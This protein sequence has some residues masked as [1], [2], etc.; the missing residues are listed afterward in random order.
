MLVNL[1]G[2]IFCFL[3][4]SAPVLDRRPSNAGPGDEGWSHDPSWLADEQQLAM[5]DCCWMLF[6]SSFGWLKGTFYRKRSRNGL[7]TR[8]SSLQFWNC[9]GSSLSSWQVAWEHVLYMSILCL[10]LSSLG[11]KHT[12]ACLEIGNYEYMELPDGSLGDKT[13]SQGEVMSSWESS[14]ESSPKIKVFVE[15]SK[16]RLPDVK[17]VS[18]FLLPPLVFPKRGFYV[19]HHQH[20]F[21]INEPRASFKGGPAQTPKT[22]VF[23]APTNIFAARAIIVQLI[24]QLI[25]EQGR[26]EKLAFQSKDR[27]KSYF[28]TTE[29][30]LSSV[31][32]PVPNWS[33]LIKTYSNC[34]HTISS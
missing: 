4:W 34:I 1:V 20:P 24:I 32:K 25:G 30:V 27:R 18:L 14:L 6:V 5:E 2:I 8:A 16:N 23:F 29:N 13:T 19:A 3:V 26:L 22:G 15:A 28:E 21:C 11:V 10:N 7:T 31:L 17:T 12:Y 9:S 33:K